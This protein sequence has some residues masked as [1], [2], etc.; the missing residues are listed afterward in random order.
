MKAVF[1]KKAETYPEIQ[2]WAKM[3]QESEDGFDETEEQTD[4]A[5]DLT[6][7]KGS[8][9]NVFM[10]HKDELFAVKS[11]A[12]AVELVKKLFEENEIN[13]PASR[14]ILLN[15]QKSRNLSNTLIYISNV[16]LKAQGNGVIKTECDA[17]E[18]LAEA[19][20]MV[21]AMEHEIPEGK[22]IAC[23]INKSATLDG[24]PTLDDFDMRY[25]NKAGLLKFLTEFE[26]D[27]LDTYETM[28]ADY[29]FN[30]QIKF[31]KEVN[32]SIVMIQ[33]AI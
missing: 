3:L 26:L 22:Y 29:D 17:D 23:V 11:P 7:R 27:T 32:G 21:K 14:R 19:D 24:D 8:I 6:K 30:D 25:F 16:I 18:A 33:V 28:M 1:S 15:L 20:E 13:T 10:G 12:E 5:I 4:E 9:G 31:V 2:M